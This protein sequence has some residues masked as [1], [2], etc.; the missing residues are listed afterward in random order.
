MVG[1][2]LYLT[3]R[4][5]RNNYQ[6]KGSIEIFLG[7]F[8]V[9]NNINLKNKMEKYNSK[10]VQYEGECLEQIEVCKGED[11][12]KIIININNYLKFLLDTINSNILI[13]NAG[14]GEKI[15]KGKS[16]DIIPS[17]EFRS[18]LETESL[19]LKLR[20][21]EI[22]FSVNEDWLTNYIQNFSTSISSPKN[23]IITGVLNNV[24]TVDLNTSI[25]KSEKPFL[26][27]S[28]LISSL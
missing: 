17:Y 7:C 21:N 15:F 3:H 1:F 24:I 12:E 5:N 13:E 19:N 18:L 8:V 4:W 20:K 11:L 28:F 26:K 23:T 6:I 27:I 9:A 10:C 2:K 25:F 16:G 14:N 22:E